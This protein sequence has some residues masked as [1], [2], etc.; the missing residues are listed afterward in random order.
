MITLINFP[1]PQSQEH[2]QQCQGF[3]FHSF[4]PVTVRLSLDTT[5][6][7]H[8]KLMLELVQPYIEGFS[9]RSIK[10]EPMDVV[11][12]SADLQAGTPKKRKSPTTDVNT[13]V[14]VAATSVDTTK[15]KK[16]KNKK[17]N[18]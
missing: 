7:Q 4:D 12:E 11:E 2:T 5:N 6:V 16:K 10:D 17:N 1:I 8:E 3:T 15:S 9:V 14:V 13:P 18:A